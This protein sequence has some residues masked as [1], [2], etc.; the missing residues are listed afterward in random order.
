[1]TR[2][3]QARRMLDGPDTGG[4]FLDTIKADLSAIVDKG[5]SLVSG[6]TAADVASGA[7]DSSNL[8][9]EDKASLH[10]DGAVPGLFDRNPWHVGLDFDPSVAAFS[11][12][13]GG[14]VLVVSC[15]ATTF[16]TLESKVLATRFALL[17]DDEV[18]ATQGVL[19]LDL[20]GKTFL[21]IALSDVPLGNRL[22]LFSTDSS[23]VFT[24]IQQGAPSEADAIR[25]QVFGAVG[26]AKDSPFSDIL[27]T[28][29]SYIDVS[30]LGAVALVAVA[31]IAL[32]MMLKTPGGTAAA[33]NLS[34][35]MV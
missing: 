24:L 26:A 29:Q 3:D 32:Y 30:A 28:I 19:N 21:V 20:T 22:T 1:M 14:A 16:D 25:K 27:S 23:V 5:E 18:L 35:G 7:V 10:I 12:A 13:H 4:S 11:H 34:A 6:A 17:W 9:R 33:S 8:S 2:L 31:G 15:D